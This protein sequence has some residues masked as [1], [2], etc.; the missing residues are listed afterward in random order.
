MRKKPPSP[1][2]VAE[3]QRLVLIW[4]EKTKLSQAEFGKQFDVG[5]QSYV[6]QCLTGRVMLTLK[7]GIAFARHLN[8]HLSEFSPR[9]DDELAK[10]VDF[11]TDQKALLLTNKLLS[12][13][14]KT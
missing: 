7:V 8:C 9:L 3:S 11:A 10:L 6:H 2:H 14:G 12:L 1:A 4:A 13:R 5:N